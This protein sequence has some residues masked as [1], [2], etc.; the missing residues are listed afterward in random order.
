MVLLSWGVYE[1]KYYGSYWLDTY[2]RPWAYST[3]PAAK[4]LVGEW[5]GTFKDPDGIQKKL[6]LQIVEPLSEAERE[7][8]ASRMSR[9]RRSRDNKQGFDGSASASS[10]LGT[11]LYEIYGAVDR[12]D[13]HQLHFSFRPV[14]EKKRVL[15]NFTLLKA[16]EG[17]WQDDALTL[18][19]HFAY[20][21]ADGTSHWSSADPR[22]SQQ[23]RIVMARSTKP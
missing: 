4:L 5:L 14:D 1:C 7:Q 23:V 2:Q 22:Y 8:N 12:N 17:S 9:R 3:D 21:R 6:S 13:Y 19:L 11:E 15:P 10:R 18:T 20:H 16:T